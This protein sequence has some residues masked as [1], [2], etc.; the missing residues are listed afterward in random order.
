MAYVLNGVATRLALSM[1]LNV[2]SLHSSLGFDVQEARRTWWIIYIQEVELSLDAG[3]P[4]SLR[5]SE[6]TMSYPTAQ[7]GSKW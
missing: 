6:M 5:S 1:G 4:V 2:E 3:R 7:V